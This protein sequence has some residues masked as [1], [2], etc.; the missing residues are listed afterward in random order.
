MFFVHCYNATSL[1]GDTITIDDLLNYSETTF[2]RKKDTRQEVSDTTIYPYSTVGLILARDP[3]VKTWHFGSGSK[4]SSKFI[5]TAAHNLVDCAPDQSPYENPRF[6]SAF[7]KGEYI[8]DARVKRFFVPKNY[9]YAGCDIAIAELEKEI[10]PNIS[11]TFIS[12]S[13]DEVDGK[14]VRVIG[15]PGDRI[16]SNPSKPIM[17]EDTGKV[18]SVEEY[19]FTHNANTYRG[20]SGGPVLIEEVITINFDD[21]I[22]KIQWSM[23]GVH[24]SGPKSVENNVNHATLINRSPAK[25]ESRMG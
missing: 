23:V 3:K 24:I 13:K 2:L 25:V 21:V 16:K 1:Y 11:L 9:C 15:Y 8:D 18:I 10:E 17:F 20:N 6:Y 14:P 4:I 12:G 7:Q 19:E 5:V 22:K